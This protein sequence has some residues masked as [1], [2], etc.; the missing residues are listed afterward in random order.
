MFSASTCCAVRGAGPAPAAAPAR[1]GPT[2][3]TRQRARDPAQEQGASTPR[4]KGEPAC[5]VSHGAVHGRPRGYG[6]FR[7]LPG[8]VEWGWGA[9]GLGT[10]SVT[11]FTPQQQKASNSVVFFVV[12]TRA[13]GCNEAFC[14]CCS[15]VFAEEI[16]FNG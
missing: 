8:G 4:E 16:S 3:H 14:G 9:L 11:L 12:S 1:P 6:A 13:A 5:G 15:S 10:S 2:E 7:A